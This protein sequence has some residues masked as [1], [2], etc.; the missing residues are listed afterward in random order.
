MMPGSRRAAVV[1]SRA[2]GAKNPWSRFSWVMACVWLVFLFFPASSLLASVAPA[3]WVG[4]GWA[5]M[6][7][8]TALY[9]FM[10]VVGL[11]R[12]VAG[13]GGVSRAQ[14]LLLALMI[15]TVVASLPAIGASAASYFPFVV[16][17][18]A[19]Q[20]H[21]WT[22]WTLSV[23]A[24]AITVGIVVFSPDGADFLSLLAILV[25]LVLVNGV[26]TWLITRSI[27]ADKLTLELATSEEREAVA[28]DVHD[29]IGHSLTVVKL[30]AQ[31]ARRLIG[32]DPERARAELEEIERITG[33]AI[34]GV[35]ATVTGL[36]SAG[37]AAQ[38]DSARVSLETAGITLSVVGDASSLS[39]A[40]SLPAGWILR[41]A[42]T[43]VLRHSSASTVRV[44]LAPGQMIVADD[45]V[46]LRG[47][48]GNGLRSMSERAAVAGA[49]CRVGMGAEGGVRVEVTW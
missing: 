36:R 18:A 9:V 10:F 14:Y 13:T 42:V 24:V 21:R 27:E 1:R 38:L 23:V 20:F 49:V 2:N 47:K 8:F 28:R 45:G 43:N 31:L 46:G 15:L 35:R 16:S 22:Y 37:L 7:A 4:V 33:E 34:Q 40:Q 48:P 6:V 19:Y 25:I 44:T 5:C 29:L 17:V 26:S 41:E 39:P 32:A 12:G 11:R 3:P 30:K